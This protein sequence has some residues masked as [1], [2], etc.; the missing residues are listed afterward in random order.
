MSPL[1]TSAREYIKMKSILFSCLI[2]EIL[3]GT[4][5]QTRRLVKFTKSVCATWDVKS[6][7]DAYD[8]TPHHNRGT[9]GFLV[10]GDM[11]YADVKCPYGVPGDLLYVKET[12]KPDPAWGQSNVS[13][14]K[15]IPGD[16]ILYKATL[17]P[18][19]PKYNTGKW[20]SPLFMPEWAARIKIKI[21]DVR[22]ERLQD[23]SDHDAKAEGVREPNIEFIGNKLD[24]Y[25][26]IM[27]KLGAGS[28]YKTGYKII[29]DSL[30]T[31]DGNAWSKNPWVWVIDFKVV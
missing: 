10:A 13:T 9:F 12:W 7:Y 8:V 16:N 4:K 2:P 29:W 23:I 24:K 15:L 6:S 18:Q 19:H 30:H 21:I 25:H 17:D 5:T 31:N 1:C 27:Q 20:R 22:V 26:T 14:K 28:H 3:D 11:G